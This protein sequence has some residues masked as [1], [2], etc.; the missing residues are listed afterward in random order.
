MNIFFLNQEIE[1]KSASLPY[2]MV[3]PG[4]RR[5]LQD[6]VPRLEQASDAR[7]DAMKS[8]NLVNK[9]YYLQHIIQKL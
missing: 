7:N 1:Y 2:R 4:G 9:T 6:S 8:K 3:C 5:I